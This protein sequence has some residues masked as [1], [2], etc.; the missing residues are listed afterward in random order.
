MRV[1][2]FK[3]GFL[4]VILFFANFFLIEGNAEDPTVTFDYLSDIDTGGAPFDVLIEGNVAYV[5]D[6]WD[7]LSSYDISNASDPVLLDNYP[8]NLAHYFHIEGDYAYIACWNY[9]YYIVNISDPTNLTEVSNFDDGSLVGGTFVSNGI[10][11]VTKTDGGVLIL[12]V[13]NPA[14]PEK[15]AQYNATGTPNVVKILDNIAYVAYWESTGSRVVFLNITDP[16]NPVYIGEYSD[17][18]DTYDIHIKDNLLI[19]ANDVMGVFFIDITDLENPIKIT[20]FNTPG[21]S[22]GL[23]TLDHYLF[24]GD[25]NTLITIDFA[26]FDNLQIVGSY[27]DTGLSQKLHIINNYLFVCNYPKGLIIYQFTIDEPTTSVTIYNVSILISVIL[28]VFFS[29]NKRQK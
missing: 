8:L 27:D 7:G 12:N 23:E 16:V 21:I 5:S 10:A 14:L 4:F 1:V 9:G 28:L 15:L 26:D 19:M 22:E 2:K 13:T 17:I 3:L 25:G 29:K 20:E 18:A 11:L 24:V 6:Y